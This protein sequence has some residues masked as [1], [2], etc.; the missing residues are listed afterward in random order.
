[1]LN[2]FKTHWNQLELNPHKKVYLAISGGV[3]S[4]VLFHLL[5][6]SEIE[7]TALHCNFQLRGKDSDA[8]AAFVK[9]LCKH[10]K[11]ECF[12]KLFETKKEQE[13]RGKGIQE[14]AR[15][16]RYNWFNALLTENNGFLLTAHHL[17]D[18][19]ETTLFNFIR[20]TDLK[21]LCGIQNQK[22]KLYRPLLPFTK[23]Q[24]RAYANEKGFEIRE[25]Y[26]NSKNE[27]SR[28]QIR[29]KVI[30][31]LKEVFPNIEL[32]S[33]QTIQAIQ[34]QHQFIQQQLSKI[35]VDLFK[36]VEYGIVIRKDA[37]KQEGLSP[38]MLV[39][40]FT[41]FGFSDQRVFGQLFEMQSGKQVLSKS[42]RF[43]I[44][45][46]RF[47]I[48]DLKPIT[49]IHKFDCEEMLK[50]NNTK[51]TIQTEDCTLQPEYQISLDLDRIEFPLI[52]RTWKDGD[53]FYPEGMKG[54]K[55]L[56]DYFRDSK[57]SIPEKEQQWILTDKNHILWIIGKRKD[58]RSLSVKTDKN[59]LN[60]V[61]NR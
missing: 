22:N 37:L 33:Q 26:S 50:R 3:D 60:L 53:Y 25:D 1:M 49:Q 43:I 27:Y 10:Y 18:S 39:K 40:L 29:N 20:G 30:P 8:D 28:N 57:F 32:R 15:D 23:Q 9:N 34:E 4:V 35:R 17:N 36:K 21:G 31:E 55:K 41:P 7:F 52:L 48:C 54:K 56:K 24:I 11:I 6:Q 14:I 59:T 16:L 61:W 2:L 51:L 12:V 45:R 47:I 38:F 13:A 46:D 19:L 5:R 42:H 58:K 44:D